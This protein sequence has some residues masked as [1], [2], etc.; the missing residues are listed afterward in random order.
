MI[1]QI[2]CAYLPY[3]LETQEAEEEIRG[4][5]LMDTAAPFMILYLE[6]YSE[7]LPRAKWTKKL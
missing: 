1:W 6:H 7:C 4:Y 3:R 2:D 5:F